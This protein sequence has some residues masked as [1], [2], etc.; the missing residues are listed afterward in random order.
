ML[1]EIPFLGPL[2]SSQSLTEEETELVI[3]V[4]P[5][6]VDPMDCNQL[7]KTLPGKES[8]V[9]DD[10]EMYL[11]GLQELPRGQRAVFENHHYKGAWKNSPTAPAYPCGAQSGYNGTGSC[12]TNSCAPAAG[13]KAP[14]V[15][16]V[17]P[18]ADA[19]NSRNNGVPS[20]GR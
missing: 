17:A 9:P 11:E 13:T 5:R 14:M 15:L 19:G 7:P 8:R 10:F 16:N 6:L 12:A 18:T 20:G 2:F 1:G 3:L 4:T